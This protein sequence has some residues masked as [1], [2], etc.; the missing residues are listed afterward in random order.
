MSVLANKETRTQEL[1]DEK[2]ALVSEKQDE[3]DLL[4]EKIGNAKRTF[5]EFLERA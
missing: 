5:A 3:L 2:N 4:E 1:L